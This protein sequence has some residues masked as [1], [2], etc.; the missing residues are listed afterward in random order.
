M[1]NFK[2]SVIGAGA[3]GTL[4]SI[5]LKTKGYTVNLMD[6]DSDKVAQLKACPVLKA[7]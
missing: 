6:K 1:A 3:S 2:F 7:T 5:I 4:M